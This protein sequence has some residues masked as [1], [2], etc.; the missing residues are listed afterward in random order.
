MADDVRVATLRA[1]SWPLARARLHEFSIAQCAAGWNASPACRVPDFVRSRFGAA[2]LLCLVISIRGAVNT[3]AP[4]ARYA[5]T[6]MDPP[7]AEFMRSHPNASP[8]AIEEYRKKIEAAQAALRKEL[9]ER[10]IPVTGAVQT[11]LNAVFVLAPPDRVAELQALPG[12]RGVA[13]MRR[14]KLEAADRSVKK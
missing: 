13:L 10:K 8:S 2:A 4:P 7:V 9:E 1:P 5:I 12:V 3:A 11:V 14:K 6:L